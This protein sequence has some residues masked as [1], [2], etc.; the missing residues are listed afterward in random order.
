MVHQ[1]PPRGF[2]GR[3]LAPVLLDMAGAA[4]RF[5]VL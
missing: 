3:E 1:R 5:Q 4:E 2:T